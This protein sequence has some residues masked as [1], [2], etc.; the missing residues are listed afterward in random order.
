MRNVIL[1]LLFIIPFQVF[2]DS[3]TT[4]VVEGMTCASCAGSIERSVRKLPDVASVSISVKAG[5][6]TVTGKE[7]KKLEANQIKQAIEEAGYKVRSTE[8]T[9]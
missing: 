9:K 6:V 8:E 1:A 3:K 5:K 4:F 2:A 7:G